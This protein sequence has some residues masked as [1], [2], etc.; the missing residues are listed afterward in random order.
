M[1][2]AEGPV[3]GNDEPA[4]DF[5]LDLS[6]RDPKLNGVRRIERRQGGFRLESEGDQISRSAT[7]FPAAM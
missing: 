5:G 3:D 4:P 6:E 1:K 7:S 2:L